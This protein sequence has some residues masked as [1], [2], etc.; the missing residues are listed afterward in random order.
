[1]LPFIFPQNLIARWNGV[2]VGC[3]QFCDAGEKVAAVY[4]VA[5]LPEGRRKGVA[6]AM[7]T[8]ILK[9]T[10]RLGFEMVVLEA[11]EMGQPVYSKLGFVGETPYRLYLKERW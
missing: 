5:V 11:T 6:S 9:E 3:C 1:M 4:A 10:R 8:T 2:A 7:M